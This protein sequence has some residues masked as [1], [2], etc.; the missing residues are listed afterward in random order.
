MVDLQAYL[1]IE[2]LSDVAKANGIE[3]PRLRGYRLMSTQKPISEEYIKQEI[4][5][6][7]ECEWRDLER[8]VTNLLEDILNKDYVRYECDKSWMGMHEDMICGYE[9]GFKKTCEVFNKYAGREDVL[10]IHSRMGGTRV[11][12]WDN[13]QHKTVVDY[14]LEAQPWF[15]DHVRDAF[16]STYCDIYAKIDPK[17]VPDKLRHPEEDGEAE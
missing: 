7:I 13:A 10:M 8:C 1:N 17:T 3:V 6:E 14:D 4:D 5:R 16:D 9:A 2:N 15:L 11:T 12:H